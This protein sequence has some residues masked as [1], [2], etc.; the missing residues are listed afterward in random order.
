MGIMGADAKKND[1]INNGNSK[2]WLDELEACCSNYRM[3]I[4]VK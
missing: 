2:K 3:Q 4:F 1:N